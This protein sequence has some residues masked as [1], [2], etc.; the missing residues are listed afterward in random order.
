MAC[1]AE[2]AWGQTTDWPALIQAAR[3][4]VVWILA[5]TSEGTAA[6]SGAIISPDGYI[7]TAA[8]VVTGASS[9]TVVVNESDEYRASVV[10]SDAAMDVAVL[11]IPGSGLTWLG[12]GDSG[13]VAIEDEVRVLG[14]PLPG[15]GVGYIAVAGIIQGTRERDGV[16]LLQHNASTAGGHSGGPV[17]NAQ[18]QVVGVH[19][20][21]LT[22]QPEYHLAISVNSAKTLIPFGVPPSGPSP[23]QPVTGAAPTSP[24]VRVPQ[25]QP[26]LVAAVRAA[27]EGAEIQLGAGTLRG[28]VS[29]T[30]PLTVKGSEGA[31]I[32]GALR[33]IDASNVSLVGLV[34]VGSVDVR[35][36]PACTLDRVSIHQSDGDGIMIEASSVVLIGCVVE[37]C[38]GNGVVASF[39]SRITMGTTTVRHCGGA[40][41]SLLL[42]SQARIAEVVVAGNNGDGIAISR[43][44]ADVRDARIHGNSGCGISVDTASQLSGGK[45]ASYLNLGA[46]V[47][48]VVPSAFVG[49][50]V[51]SA[52]MMLVPAGSFAMGDSFSEGRSDE[53][54][55]H[56][57]YVSAFYMDCYE[58]TEALWNEVAAWAE[59][60]GYDIPSIAIGNESR[61]PEYPAV[62]MTWYEAA[63]WANAR[64]EKEGLTPAYYTSPDMCD[65][66]VYRR[67]DVDLQAS[68]VLW[69]VGYRLPT[70][71]EWEKAARGGVAGRR[72][73]WSA[74]DTIQH[75]RAN[76]MS[77]TNFAYDT[78]PTR[79]YH[80]VYSLYGGEAVYPDNFARDSPVGSF[81]ANGYGLYDMA[82]NVWEWCWD[83]Y[84]SGYYASSPGTDPRGPASGSHRVDRGG[85]DNSYASVCRAANRDWGEAESRLANYGFRLVRTGP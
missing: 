78:S 40:G 27:A 67:G 2:T 11:K 71:A 46:D 52:S 30:K 38:G 65:A 15:A 48:G 41:I 16:T 51:S 4:A 42:N 66:T 55:M 63:K 17:I 77:T 6:G 58:V 3:P 23:V 57:V 74:V 24:V 7:L 70:E 34:I 50:E 44:I 49:G 33:I 1:S 21:V 47:C 73:P 53:L 25:D 82:G 83:W 31:T 5:E 64:S 45:N 84:D 12:L 20:A 22:D 43:S 26:T 79:G 28:D 62:S 37:G 80:P 13:Q 18:G 72:F 61:G 81:A 36:S 19:S 35:D 60:Q 56:T 29:I 85:A 32:E 59:Q 8:H 68:W 75:S 69:D 39:G 10:R 76:Y 54:P 9:I 14:Y